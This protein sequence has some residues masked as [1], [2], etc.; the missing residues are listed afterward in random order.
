MGAAR[1][2]LQ[3]GIIGLE[4]RNQFWKDSWTAI[5]IWPGSKVFREVPEEDQGVSELVL[6]GRRRVKGV[7]EDECG[8]P[9]LWSKDHW[10]SKGRA[11]AVNGAV[12]R[13]PTKLRD[14]AAVCVMTLWALGGQRDTQGCCPPHYT[15]SPSLPMLFLIPFAKK[16]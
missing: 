16:L 8:N 14:P 1:S 15:G 4:I 10:S 11:Q 13:H 2:N 9:Q 3:R 7:T 6:P 5:E 12:R